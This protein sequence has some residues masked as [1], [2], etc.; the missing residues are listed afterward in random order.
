MS[1]VRL[2]LLEEQ[3]KG[4]DPEQHEE[5]ITALKLLA[6]NSLDAHT[7]GLLGR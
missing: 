5:L 2:Q 4:W 1:E 7:A 3:L 6:D